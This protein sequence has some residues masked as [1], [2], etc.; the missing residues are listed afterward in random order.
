[1]R[2]DGDK[3]LIAVEDGYRES[4]ESWK[5]LLTDALE[6][7]VQMDE[8]R[9]QMIARTPVGRLGVPEDMAAAILYLASPAGSYVTGKILEVDGG[10]IMSTWPWPIPSNL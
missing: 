8:L 7:F 3:E 10:S 2:P 6:A 9:T 4:A 1:V 5:T